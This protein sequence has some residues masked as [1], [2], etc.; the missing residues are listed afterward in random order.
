[1][2]STKSKVLWGIVT[3]LVVFY[4]LFP[5]ASILATSFKAPSD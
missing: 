4:A 3:V 1:M 5:V 2:T